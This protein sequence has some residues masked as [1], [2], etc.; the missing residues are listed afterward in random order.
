MLII[1]SIYQIPGSGDAGWVLGPD[2]TTEDVVHRNLPVMY[3]YGDKHLRGYFSKC[4]ERYRIYGRPT[5]V[6]QQL[7]SDSTSDSPGDLPGDSSSDK[8]SQH[9]SLVSEPEKLDNQSQASIQEYGMGT[10]P[11]RGCCYPM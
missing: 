6:D 1:T 2:S 11:K 5:R 8:A 9:S 7:S 3:A 10:E 4:Q